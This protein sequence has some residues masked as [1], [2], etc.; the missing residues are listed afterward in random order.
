MSDE[1][2]PSIF[3]RRRSVS[4]V[5]APTLLNEGS[6]EQYRAALRD[7]ILDQQKND[8]LYRMGIFKEFV[9]FLNA[10]V[11]EDNVG[12]LMDV[13]FR[14]LP[15]MQEPALNPGRPS[16]WSG[17]DGFLLLKAVF[18]LQL[19]DP[20]I[21]D[22]SAAQIA[23][24]GFGWTLKDEYD[25]YKQAVRQLRPFKLLFDNLMIELRKRGL[26]ELR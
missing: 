19:K 20:A 25:A 13:A 21:S 18:E 23:C 6:V 12:Y 16:R 8:V 17:E 3:R 11:N 2:L 24:I 1:K 5:H 7:L 4:K 10:S 22:R 26:S 15:A 14:D 9:A